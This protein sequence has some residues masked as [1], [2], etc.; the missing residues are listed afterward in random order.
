MRIH[1]AMSLTRASDLESSSSRDSS[2]DGENKEQLIMQKL[3]KY[4]LKERILMEVKK[5][6]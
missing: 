6:F 3:K 1:L 2:G 4:L 5:E